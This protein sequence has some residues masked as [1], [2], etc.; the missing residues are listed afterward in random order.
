MVKAGGDRGRRA[1]R[2]SEEGR[3][4]EETLLWAVLA[5]WQVSTRKKETRGG[6]CGGAVGFGVGRMEETERQEKHGA[7]RGGM[8]SQDRGVG[9]MMEV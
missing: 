4:L 6:M 7:G 2:V 3:L 5:G 1:Q 8:E 9:F